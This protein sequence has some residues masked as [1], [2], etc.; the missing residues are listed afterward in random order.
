M[1][2]IETL[3]ASIEQLLATIDPQSIGAQVEIATKSSSLWLELSYKYLDE[4]EKAEK[5]IDKSRLIDMAIKCDRQ[6]NEWAHQARQMAKVAKV[7]QLREI[8]QRLDRRDDQARQFEA[9]H[10]KAEA[11]RLAEKRLN[12]DDDD[13]GI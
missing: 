4:S 10:E 1:T 7:D 6:A 5:A 8:Q 13:D 3:R 9:L 12:R 2:A 11:K